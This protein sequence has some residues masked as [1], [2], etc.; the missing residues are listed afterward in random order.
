MGEEHHLVHRDEHMIEVAPQPDEGLHI[1]DGVAWL[2][3]QSEAGGP[4]GRGLTH[5]FIETERLWVGCDTEPQNTQFGTPIIIMSTRCNNN[6]VN[7]GF[8]KLMLCHT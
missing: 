1:V 4:D 8:E 3:V 7:D 6:E 5:N 2:N